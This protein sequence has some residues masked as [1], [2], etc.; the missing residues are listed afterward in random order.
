MQIFGAHSAIFG[1]VFYQRF[2]RFTR[3]SQTF[4][5]TEPFS[6]LVW[7]TLAHTNVFL[8]KIQKFSKFSAYGFDLNFS[9]K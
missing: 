2:P 1:D 4:W 6:N 3:G 9:E 7:E 5:L 8:K